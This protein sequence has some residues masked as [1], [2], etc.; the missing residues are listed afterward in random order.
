MA[1]TLSGHES[2]PKLPVGVQAAIAA[3]DNDWRTAIELELIA[4]LSSSSFRSSPRSRAFLKFVT[5]ETLAGRQD[6]LKER[7]I[8][9]V[10]LAR[11]PAYDTGADS[12]VRVR[13]NDVRKRLA[14]YYSQSSPKAGYRIELAAGSYI[15][16]FIQAEPVPPRAQL[17]SSVHRPPPMLLWQLAAPTLVALFLAL[18]VIRAR[19]ESNDSFTAFWSKLLAHRSSIL[20]E[21]DPA[22]DGTSVSPEMA[23][24]AMW[25]STVAT[26]F[27]LPIR[28]SAGRERSSPSVCVIRLS[29]IER[30]PSGVH[31]LRIGAATLA[32]A[33]GADLLLVSDNPSELRRAVQSLSSR[34]A[35][36][37]IH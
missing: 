4:L 2:A 20:V 12:V 32:S 11:D 5:E 34:E 26:S 35:F 9:V 10:V 14:S 36:P 21:L 7:T 3:T 15:P 8:G 18:G 37:A 17:K 27:Q 6:S 16:G 19:V 1:S 30:P 25:F 22:A 23:E 24:A 33:S 29:T 31:T 13:A 28:M